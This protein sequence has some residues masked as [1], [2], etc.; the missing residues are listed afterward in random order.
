ME[1]KPIDR[2]KIQQDA[3]NAI[4][5]L[6]RTGAVITMRGGKCLLGLKYI[7]KFFKPDTKIL[8]VIPKLSIE[9][10]WKDDAKKFNF[11]HLLP[12]IKF[13]TYLSLHKQL[14]NY[15]I[16]ILDESHSL[17]Y[18]HKEW[19]DL[20]KGKI[21]GLTGTEPKFVGSEKWNMSTIFCPVVFKYT[22]EE[23]VNDKVLNDYIIEVYK[24]NLSPI[25]NL[26][27]TTKTGKSWMTSELESYN[28]WTK[29][30]DNSQN[31]NEKMRLSVLRMKAM[32]DFPG[33][34]QLVKKLLNDTK[35]KI[36]V[37][38]NTQK[39][40]DRILPHSYHSKNPD[41]KDNLDKLKK[42]KITKLSCVLQLGEGITIPGL[43]EAI[44]MHSYSGSSPKTRQRGGRCLGL[45]PNDT[46]TI[47]ILCYKNTK[48][49]NW[50]N[51]ALTDYNDDKIVYIDVN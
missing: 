29:R 38:A 30:L 35:N 23:A 2:S 20:Y 46:C 1:N 14:L 6:K 19:L 43:K 47:K 18:S 28:Y 15:D 40:A 34:E 50:V 4:G 7:N 32:M 5:D 41:S 13:V 8:I 11:E 10:S 21:L 12:N 25:K 48:D 31:A 16:L 9:E 24:L 51:S 33:K 49:E 22:T 42:G 27:Q 3:L 44:I 17:T 36:I 37:F 39:Q 26:K 45:D